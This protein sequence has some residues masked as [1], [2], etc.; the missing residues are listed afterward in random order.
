MTATAPSTPRPTEEPPDLTVVACK[1]CGGEA[2]VYGAVDFNKTCEDRHTPVFS[3]AGVDIPYHRCGSCGLIFTIAFDEFTPAQFHQYIYNDAYVLADPDFT[4]RRPRH[5]AGL[6]QRHFGHVASHLRVLDYGGGN[7][8]LAQ[9]LRERGFAH[10]VS[11]DPFYAG[12]ERPEGTFDLV[13]AFEVLEHTTTPRETI[14]DMVSFMGEE[15]MVFCSTLLQ[16]GDIDQHRLGWWYA[17]PRNG[18]VSL[19]TPAAITAVMLPMRLT[20]GSAGDL[21]HVICR[22][23]LPEFA[24][25]LLG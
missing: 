14:A 23:A 20:W 11:Y 18:H 13:T 25:G 10:A 19:Y 21:Q 24:K 5:N 7:G 1:C 6:L 17:A 12:S 3:A 22:G 9:L 2:R 15:G 4:D 16:P 8:L